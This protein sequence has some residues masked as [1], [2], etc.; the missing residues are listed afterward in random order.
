MNIYNAEINRQKVLKTND[1][2]SLFNLFAYYDFGE[3]YRENE[4]SSFQQ[5]SY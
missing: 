5:S 3:N 4:Q 1:I 2:T